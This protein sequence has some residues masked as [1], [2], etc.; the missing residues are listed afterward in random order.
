MSAKTTDKEISQYAL[1]A[2]TTDKTLLRSTAI[3][4]EDFEYTISL[5]SYGDD[6][7]GQNQNVDSRQNLINDIALNS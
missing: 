4:Y 2:R 6:I 5:I 1:P 7:L 3:N